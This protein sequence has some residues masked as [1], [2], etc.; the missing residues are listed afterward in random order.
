MLAESVVFETVSPGGGVIG[1]GVG[2]VLFFVLPGLAFLI[3][4]LRAVCRQDRESLVQHVSGHAVAF[5]VMGLLFVGIGGTVGQW[6]YQDANVEVVLTDTA[7]RVTGGSYDLRF[8]GEST[9]RLPRSALR[10]SEARVL[11]P[12][13]S[14]PYATQKRMAG[15]NIP[16]LFSGWFR[17]QNGK[18]AYVYLVGASETLLLPTTEGYVLLLDVQRPRDV[19]R[20]VRGENGG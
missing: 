4:F 12:I 20:R 10:P 16:G 2:L 7:L 15:A 14:T 13:S 6:F 3:P 18:E 19:L 8:A 11:S 17:L 9:D 1:F 5:A